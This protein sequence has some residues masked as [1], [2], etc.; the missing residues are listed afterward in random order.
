MLSQSTLKS[1]HKTQIDPERLAPA[2]CVSQRN[3]L[4]SC[5]NEVDLVTSVGQI[6]FCHLKVVADLVLCW[7][8]KKK[9][10]LIGYL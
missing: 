4:R 8:E 3:Y 10:V 2:V 1:Y 9:N 5:W 7:P 6:L